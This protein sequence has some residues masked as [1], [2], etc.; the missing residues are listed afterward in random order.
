[1]SHERQGTTRR[2]GR[3]GRVPGPSH[4]QGAASC[5]GHAAP[6]RG[7]SHA[8]AGMSRPRQ[9]ATQGRGAAQRA[10]RAGPSSTPGERAGRAAPRATP[11][12]EAGACHAAPWPRGGSG[13]GGCEEGEGCAMPGVGAALCAAPSRGRHAAQG[14]EAERAWKRAAPGRVRRVV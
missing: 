14:G 1:M 12:R 13:R 5:R 7:G 3:E 8:K 9:S 11:G 6:S 4:G 10:G 2:A